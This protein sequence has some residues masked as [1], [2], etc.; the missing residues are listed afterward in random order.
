M[1]VVATAGHVDHGKSTLVRLL[2][3]MEPDRWAEERRRGMTID[4]GFAWTTLPTGET[5]AFVDVPGHE[6][7]VG[8]MLAGIGPVPAALLVVAADQGWQA[9]SAEHLDALDA[10]GVR[11]GLLA[12]TRCDLA[13]PSEAEA[14][15][16]AHLGRTSLGALPTVRVSGR[17]GEGLDDLLLA[18]A[19]VIEDLPPPTTDGDVRLWVDRAFTIR[20]AGTVVTGTLPAGTVRVGDELALAGGG[21]RVVVRGIQSL[22]RA[23]DSVAAVAR[24]ALNLRGVGLA[25]IGRG[26]ALVTP[27]RWLDTDQVD[28]R[29]RGD[30]AA[31]LPG[32]VILHVGSAAVAATVRPLGSDTARL[33]LQRSLPLRIGDAAA[34]RDPGRRRIAAGVRVLDVRPPSLRRRGAAVARA[35]VLAALGGTPD[36]ADEVRRRGI[37]PVAELRAMGAQPPTA[38]LVGDWLVDPDLL[39]ELTARA[40]RTV[41]EYAA[42]HPLDVGMPLELLRRELRLPDVRLVPSVVTAPYRVREG[43]VVAETTGPGLPPEVQAAVAELRADLT[44]EPYAAPGAERLA[45]LGLRSRELG[46]VARAGS[47]L[48]VTDGIYLLPGADA[49]AAAVL[50]GLEQPFTL[51]AARQALGTSRRVAVPLLELLARQGRTRRL[52]D[53]T[54]EV[55]GA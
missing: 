36:G 41:G 18:L 54:H 16:L 28:V 20:G 25:D 11:H 22:G 47:L 43:R 19:L 8:N 5:V 7:F 15:A 51:S 30:Q 44:R 13:D 42:A 14:E 52:P 50:A 1:H 23:A 45:A 33:R 12:V 48:K 38:P 34:L 21:P 2:T 26:D 46:A 27:R 40:R 10:L 32:E 6:R 31:D 55:L 53:D 24:V 17:T 49:T 37:V 29:L 4:L 39:V 9:Q 35:A 3:G